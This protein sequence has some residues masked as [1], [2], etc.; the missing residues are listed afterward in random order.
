MPSVERLEEL[1]RGV[2]A[3][4]VL[5]GKVSLVQP[6]GPK[7]ALSI[8]PAFRIVD[9]DTRSRLSVARVR[10]AR[11]VAPVDAVPEPTAH[12]WALVAALNDL[13]Q[14]TNHHLSGPFTRG[15][16]ERLA[17]LVDEIL[18]AVPPPRS[19]IAAIA[20]HTL[21]ARVFEL[22]RK[23]TLVKWWTGSANFRGEPPAGRLLKWK[24]FRR[25]TTDTS[26]IALPDLSDGVRLAKERWLS[27]LALFLTRSPLTDLATAG[28]VVPTFAWSPATLAFVFTPMGSKL[29]ARAVAAAHN[30]RANG[31]LEAA[32][33]RLPPGKARTI[34]MRF[35]EE[36]AAK[37]RGLKGLE[38]EAARAESKP[39]DEEEKETPLEETITDEE[40]GLPPPSP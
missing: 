8:N 5:G 11:L 21:F 10:I 2:L 39:S 38:K 17:E 15:R 22:V 24:S 16:H 37:L 35:S 23:D 4:L 25:V 31:A 32:I 29:G 3:P 33:N 6:F 27:S 9:D 26:S 34:A 28:R 40:M 20:R 19:M 18:G 14:A 12:D 30:T 13:L 36:A 1:A 7:L